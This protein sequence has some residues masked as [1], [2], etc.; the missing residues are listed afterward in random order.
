MAVS[1]S[2][3][4]GG[5]RGGV[6]LQLGIIGAD[7]VK[8]VII[9]ALG[10]PVCQ[11]RVEERLERK[12]PQPLFLDLP[13]PAGCARVAVDTWPEF[14]ARQF[15]L[16]WFLLTPQLWVEQKEPQCQL[17]QMSASSW[18]MLHLASAG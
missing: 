7:S 8:T 16:V 12:S 9:L 15:L 3:S 17:F 5:A 13:G 10:A 6:G 11:V 14:L 18:L 1:D 4:E 2:G